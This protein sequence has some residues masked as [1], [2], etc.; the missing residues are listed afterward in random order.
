MLRYINEETLN[1]DKSLPGLGKPAEAVKA[2]ISKPNRRTF[3]KSVG[4][5]GGLV[6][7]M[8]LLP[9]R[10]A[11]AFD[12]YETGAAAM[13]HKTVTNPHVFVAIDPDGTITLTT[14]R[15][16]MGTGARTGV[17]MVLADELEADWSRVVIKQAEGDEPKYGNQDTDGSRSLRHFVQPMRQIGA[18]VRTMLE[19]AA[20]EQWGVPVEL[21]KAHDHAVYLM[22]GEGDDARRTGPRLGYGE[23]AAAAMKLPVP[24]FEELTFKT[25][26][27][28]RYMGKG[29]VPMTDIH[30]ITTGKA[31][32]GA[33][34]QL[35]GMKYA[36]V[37][38]PPVVGGKVKSFDAAA[39]LKVPGVEKVVELKGSIPPAKFAPL[40]GIAVVANNTWAAI[41]GRDALVIE[42]DDGP[43][44]VYNTKDFKQEMY[45][46][47]KKPGKVMRAQGDADKAFKNAAKVVTAEYYQPHM[48]HAQ[49]EPLVAI[50]NFADGKLDIW[51]PVQSP[52]GTRTDTAAALGMKPDDVTVNVSLLGGGFG[53]KSKCDFVIEAAHVSKAVGAPVKLQWTREDDMRHGFYATTS[54]EHLEAAIDKNNK[55]V[56]WRHRSVSPT[57]FSTFVKDPGVTSSLEAG[58]GLM[59]TPVNIPNMSIEAGTAMSHTRI[60]WFRSVSNVPRAFGVQSFIAELAHELGRD[61]KDMLLEIIGPSRKIDMHTA[62]LKGDLWNYGEPYTEFPVDTGRLSN[63]VNLAADQSGWGKKLPKGEGMGIAVHRSFVTYVASVVRVKID[64]D[65]TIRIP[66]VHTAVDCGYCINPERVRSQMEGAA[67]MGMTLALHS[68]LD[69][70]NGAVQQSNFHDYPMVRINSYPE[71]VNT[72]IVDHPFSVHATGVG[73]PG[74]P[75][76]APALANAIFAASGKRLR[77]M[78]FGDK[79]A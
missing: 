21:V 39:A 72:H 41:K 57:I 1:A 76:F 48:S 22:S 16:E 59:D 18:S 13:P 54:V 38:R 73:E 32:Y 29:E 46:T 5:T 78:P 24:T 31:R 60:G 62:G 7:A 51:A 68:G 43:H 63:V 77:E 42:W 6:L 4:G 70:V 40:G 61:P 15:S 53:R 75:P 36:V 67:V 45:K 50:A 9:A 79:I 35:E 23:I 28:F 71:Q 58:M 3:M 37:A 74:V 30:D 8:Q 64:D 44:A 26:D 27:E 69:Y 47:A 56:G 25:D 10:T 55:V 2:L 49:M 34:M 20:A 11:Q 33:D 14:H 12:P 65:G 17:P 19:L 52:Y 66:E